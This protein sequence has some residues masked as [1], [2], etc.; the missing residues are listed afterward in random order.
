[1]AQATSYCDTDALLREFCGWVPAYFSSA[2]P[3]LKAEPGAFPE[4]PGGEPVVSQDC[5]GWPVACCGEFW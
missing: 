4:L 3:P 1:L 2:V 5:I